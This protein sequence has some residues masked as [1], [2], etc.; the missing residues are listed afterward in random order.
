MAARQ[1]Q[2]LQ[3]QQQIDKEKDT[4]QEQ[5]ELDMPPIRRGSCKYIKEL[6]NCD[7]VYLTESIISS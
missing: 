6:F 7:Y 5:D 3:Q 1:R 4:E 2:R